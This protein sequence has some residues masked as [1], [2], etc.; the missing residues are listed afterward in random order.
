MW[1]RRRNTATSPGLHFRIYFKL[2]KSVMPD[3]LWTINFWRSERKIFFLLQLEC[4]ETGGKTFPGASPVSHVMKTKGAFVCFFSITEI[5]YCEPLWPSKVWIES[6]GCSVLAK[7]CQERIVELAR[8]RKLRKLKS[9]GNRKCCLD[10]IVILATRLATW[11]SQLW[12][13][14]GLYTSLTWIL[15]TTYTKMKKLD[16]YYFSV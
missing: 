5:N 16:C 15:K 4:W 2:L 3:V 12:G 10:I 1:N 11:S 6:S 14:S 13:E 8:R 7:L 9:N